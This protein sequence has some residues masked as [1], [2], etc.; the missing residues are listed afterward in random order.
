M[1]QSTLSLYKITDSLL[2]IQNEILE[3]E[4]ELTP[5]L[6]QRLNS[7]QLSRLDKIEN[8]LWVIQNMSHM[9]EGMKAEIKRLQDL[10]KSR[11][12]CA[13]RLKDYLVR[14]MAALDEKKLSTLNFSV[15][16]AKSGK[17]SIRP[18][19]PD[20]PPDWCSEEITIRKFRYDMA[21]ELVK[22]TM[23][24]LVGSVVDNENGL[25]IERKEYLRIR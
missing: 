18:I 7:L 11:E 14:E 21:E 17:F 1:A 15:T 3:N 2:E 13:Q 5:E 24:D 9:T 4:G 25:I 19:D 6:E 10:K 8:I 20:N 12:N 23:P 22:E 16:R